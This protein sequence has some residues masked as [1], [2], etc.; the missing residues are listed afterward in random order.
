MLLFLYLY[1]ILL[2]ELISYYAVIKC[3]VVVYEINF[4][5]IFASSCKKEISPFTRKTDQL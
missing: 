4:N 2:I 1:I 3:Q 5:I